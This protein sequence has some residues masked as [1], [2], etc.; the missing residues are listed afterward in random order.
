[1]QDSE[2]FAV[3]FHDVAGIRDTVGYEGDGT[4]LPDP[5]DEDPTRAWGLRA[6][7]LAVPMVLQQPNLPRVLTGATMDWSL[8]HYG[9]TAIV[10]DTP[11]AQHADQVLSEAG[12]TRQD[13]LWLAD[14]SLPGWHRAMR[15]T[16]TDIVV[17]P[18]DGSVTIEPDAANSALDDARVQALLRCLDDPHMMH[19]VSL[20]GDD[21]TMAVAAK[22]DAD[23]NGTAWS[24]IHAPG[25][26]EE[27]AASLQPNNPAVTMSA[28][29]V[30]GDVIRTALQVE[31]LPG[32]APAEAM[33][34]AGVPEMPFP[35]F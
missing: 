17:L 2:R 33:L 10:H 19:L 18:R 35:G 4:E 20:P 32:T 5:A 34:V 26:A 13:D 28:P 27:V 29:E 6:T 11:D 16:D 9:S 3:G 1:M 12:W 8:S 23:G 7:R 22:V 25:R 30:D 31:P 24:C 14:D 21:R 15:V